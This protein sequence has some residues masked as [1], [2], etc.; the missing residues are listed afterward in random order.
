MVPSSPYGQL[1][2]APA[3]LFPIPLLL[4]PGKAAQA[5]ELFFPLTWKTQIKLLAP[6]FQTHPV[7]TITTIWRLSQ[8]TEDISLCVSPTMSFCVVH[9]DKKKKTL[10][11]GEEKMGL[12]H[13]L[14]VGLREP[15]SQETALS[16]RSCLKP[17]ATARVPLAPAM[18][19]PTR[20]ANYLQQQK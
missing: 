1:V 7:P 12:H 5:L 16:C 3:A 17:R 20:A 18:T 13:T 15:W 8:C 2:H 19:A 11:W 10:R 6:G 14:R 4:V 9:S